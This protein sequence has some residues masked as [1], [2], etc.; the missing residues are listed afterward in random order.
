MRGS[1][2]F[3]RSAT[4][5]GFGAP[6]EQHRLAPKRLPS[7]APALGAPPGLDVEKWNAAVATLA[8]ELGDIA[9]QLDE[10]LKVRAR[11]LVQSEVVDSETIA[12]SRTG[13]APVVL[14]LSGSLPQTEFTGGLALVGKPGE[15]RPFLMMV[16]WTG[17]SPFSLQ[18]I[19][20]DGGHFR[21]VWPDREERQKSASDVANVVMREV[22]THAADL[23][24]PR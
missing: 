15:L 13:G 9:R 23:I 16:Q 1:W 11:I 6:A 14:K 12:R 21:L 22:L 10:Q 18:E 19:H 17:A 2:A 5:T 4:A 3:T 7:R 8:A 20:L 24:P